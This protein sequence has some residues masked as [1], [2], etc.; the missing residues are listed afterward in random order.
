MAPGGDGAGVQ[1]EDTGDMLKWEEKTQKEQDTFKAT[2]AL[3]VKVKLELKL[4]LE[5]LKVTVKLELEAV[6]KLEL[7]VVAKLELRVVTRIAMS[8]RNSNY[9]Y[10]YDDTMEEEFVLEGGERLLSEGTNSDGQEAG[11][12]AGK[13][14]DNSGNKKKKRKKKKLDKADGEEEEDKVNGPANKRRREH[15]SNETVIDLSSS[16][17]P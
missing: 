8:E 2:L 1:V 6:L 17:N 3:M 13:G 12:H 4:E 10:I 11:E 14:M 5:T 15:D 7:G 9:N 16:Q